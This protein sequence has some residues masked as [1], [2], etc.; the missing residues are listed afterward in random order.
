MET[1]DLKN[2]K[3]AR[4]YS[5]AGFIFG[6]LLIFSALGNL[7]ASM[8]NPEL[9]LLGI[10]I[11]LVPAVA[12]IVRSFRPPIGFGRGLAIVLG[13]MLAGQAPMSLKYAASQKLWP[14]L[15][16]GLVGILLLWVGFRKQKKVLERKPETIAET[17]EQLSSSHSN[18][19]S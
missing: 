8:R 16:I 12:I 11:P 2:K 9:S 1:V 18:S 7:L 4:K 14:N 3:K 5:I 17:T 15:I 10:F 6:G 13:G 19:D